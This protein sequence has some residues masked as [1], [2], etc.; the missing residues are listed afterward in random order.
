MSHC[1]ILVIKCVRNCNDFFIQ[2][3]IAELKADRLESAQM[4]KEKFIEKEEIV[5]K[6]KSSS[7]ATI[8]GILLILDYIYKHGQKFLPDY[9]YFLYNGEMSH[10]VLKK[11]VFEVFCCHTK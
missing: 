10:A 8:D 2:D 9:R 11:L 3:C 4:E 5:P 6:L 7:I 1:R